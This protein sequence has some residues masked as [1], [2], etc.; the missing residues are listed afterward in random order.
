MHGHHGF[1]D[2]PAAALHVDPLYGAAGRVDLVEQHRHVGRAAVGGHPE[3]QAAGV[4]LDCAPAQEPATSRCRPGG[5]SS[6][7]APGGG[8]PAGGACLGAPVGLVADL[9]GPRVYE[10]AALV[11]GYPRAR[12][13]HRPILPVPLP[14]RANR[15]YRPGANWLRTG[16]WAAGPGG[17]PG[18]AGELTERQ[19][20]RSD[21][22]A[23]RGMVV[24]GQDACRL[25]RPAR[26]IGQATQQAKEWRHV[27]GDPLL[28]VPPPRTTR[29]GISAGR[30][31]LALPVCPE[32]SSARA[33]PPQP[34]R[35]HVRPRHRRT[36]PSP[37]QP[38]WSSP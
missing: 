21:L 5:G 31:Y 8:G 35:G 23:G 10:P 18:R 28:G 12:G 22:A 30:G 26:A 20:L 11:R 7:S 34:R 36:T 27:G 1:Q 3:G 9:G 15:A 4:A 29:R 16:R 38:G 17:V 24:D 6:R 19:Q 32:S 37:S 14:G 2:S 33:A 25:H 13:K